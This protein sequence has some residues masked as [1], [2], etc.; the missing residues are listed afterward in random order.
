MTRKRYIKLLMSRGHSRDVAEFAAYAARVLDGVSSPEGVTPDGRV[1]NNRGYAIW[2]ALETG[3]L[4]ER[5]A[6]RCGADGDPRAAG[7]GGPYRER[8]YDGMPF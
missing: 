5:P 4:K 8:R 1:V 3:A 2:W 7:G 6:A